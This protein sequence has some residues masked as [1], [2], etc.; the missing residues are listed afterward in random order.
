MKGKLPTIRLMVGI[1][2]LVGV[3]AFAYFALDDSLKA[4]LLA[5]SGGSVVL[6]VAFPRK[7]KNPDQCL[8]GFGT[9][10]VT[11]GAWY[12][13]FSS[14][15]WGEVDPMIQLATMLIAIYF[16]FGALINFYIQQR[17]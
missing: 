16:V 17:N 7:L 15:K 14:E 4:P 9:L 12:W 6:S 2:S 11:I 5:L 10:F 1:I 3:F 8:V 13:L